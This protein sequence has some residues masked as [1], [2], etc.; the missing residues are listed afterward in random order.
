MKEVTFSIQICVIIS[1]MNVKKISFYDNFICSAG[2]CSDTCC[3][4]WI[5]PLDDDAIALYHAQKGMLLLRLI[6]AE[7]V[8]NDTICFNKNSKTCP[9][10]TKDNLC[11][12]Q[13]EHGEEF[14]C[15]TCREYPR[16]L[17][18]YKYFSKKCLDLSCPE[19][20][21]LFLS[22]IDNLYYEDS[23]ELI[24]YEI[25][26]TNDDEKYLRSLF[27]LEQSFISHINN[28][29][30]SLEIIF[31]DLCDYAKK[32]Q[33]EYINNPDT[34]I[35]NR[36]FYFVSD[37]GIAFD[38]VTT[39]RILHTKFYHSKLKSTDPELYRLCKLYHKKF[40]KLAISEADKIIGSLET[41]IKKVY[42]EIDI[43]LR[44]YSIYF[45]MCTFMSIYEDYSFL[46]HTSLAL[47]HTH[48][49]KLFIYL[50]I[51]NKKSISEDDLIKIITAYERRAKH[52]SQI[53]SE[54]Y[55]E[56]YEI[57]CS[58]TDSKNPKS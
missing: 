25:T 28:K 17:Y 13:K 47:I 15:A 35:L 54:M 10:F 33:D 51:D 8:Q 30:L 29:S 38:S 49:L 44:N 52:N 7:K 11:Y 48:M 58:T 1:I 26:V 5:I 57:L 21:K 6:L 23:D 31:R 12:L 37:K 39:D 22:N 40:N 34:D 3:K 55:D 32:L 19:V 16:L 45:I 41:E 50:H 56:I 36:S 9:F 46:K 43:L 24:N 42:P 53:F 14:L 2:K 27:Q 4:G 20:V 18:N